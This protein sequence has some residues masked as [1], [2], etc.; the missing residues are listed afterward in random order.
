MKNL[1]SFLKIINRIITGFILSFLMIL[2]NNGVAQVQGY[3][4]PNLDQ[5]PP[6]LRNANP[7]MTDNPL[8]TVITIGNWDNF[9]LGVDFAENNMAA[10]MS[11]PAW[12]FT[13]YNINAGHHTEN[14]TDWANVTPNFGTSLAGDPVVTYDSIGNLYYINMFGSVSGIKVIKSTDNG[15]TWGTPVTGCLGEDKCWIAC[16]QT[17]GPYAN[18]VYVCMTNNVSNGVGAFAR[19]IDHGSTFTTTFSPNTQ[20]LPGMMVCV[21]PNGNIQGGSVYAVTNSGSATASTYTFY[22]STNGGQSFTLMSSQQFSGYVGTYVN[23][24]NSVEG[25]RTRPYP[26]I[27]ADNSYGPHRGRFYNIYA[28]NDP[29]GNGNKPDIWVRYSD[30]AGST[31]SA[32]IRV[33]DDP[34]PQSHNQW[35]PAPWCDKETGRLYVQWMDTRDCPTND[36]ALIYASYSDD[37]G[38]TWAANQAISNK[39]MKI[40][41]P[42]CGGG[43]TP[44]YQGDYNGIV[45]NKKV[46]MAGWTDFRD[47]TFMS[48]TAYFPDFA[49]A[50]DH[51]SDT[52]F[53]PIDST[54]FQVMIPAIKLYSD[55]V[56]V[57]GT[58]TPTPSTGTLDFVYPN[59]NIITT[60]P[61]SLAVRVVL[62]GNVPNGIY[63]ATF[64]G[65]GPNGT[66]VHLRTATI[67]VLQGNGFYVQATA[68]PGN[69]CQ[70]QTSQLNVNIIGGTP[71][72]TFLWTPSTWLNNPNIQ[73]PVATPMVSTMYHVQVTDAASK[74]ETDSVNIV[75]SSGPVQ[76]GPISGPQVVCAGT[77][78]NYSI[79]SV[80][81]AT[82]Y[83]WTVPLNATITSG[84]NTTGITVLWD[85]T[86][87]NISVIAGN[88]CGNSTPSV[89]A[90]TV[91]QAP[92][93]LGTINGPDP[94]CNNE[95]AKYYVT[96][97]GNT[98][99]YV[100]TV[101]S[102]VTIISGQGTDTIMVQWGV[103][104]D[105][106]SVFARNQCGSTPVLSKKV[107]NQALPDPAGTISGKDTICKDHTGYVFTVG[108]ITGAT[109]YNWTLPAGFTVTGGIGTN[110]ITINSGQDTLSGKISVQGSNIC[111]NGISF[112]KPLVVE[113]CS[114]ISRNDLSS[115]VTIYPNPARNE[116]F[117]KIMGQEKN[118]DLV[119]TDL[120]GKAVYKESLADLATEFS[121]KID[122]S[123]FPAGFYFIKLSSG[124]RYFAGKVVIRQE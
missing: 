55:T 102:D 89:L 62:T 71:P 106:I 59:G 95:N 33:N 64:K 76:P 72:F 17:S 13:A 63:T 10:N 52:L 16:D 35:Q 2:T 88:N 122:V 22:R 113:D 7:G 74:V 115:S 73:N 80:P 85:T 20:N 93:P 110:S 26:F 60:F 98:L 114:G 119:I 87:G 90:V 12:Y 78:T 23:S 75:V 49:M 41:C 28:S 116:L 31:W 111:G 118:L 58:I 5:V 46:S 104:A 92:A 48:T 8:S 50:L 82:S 15:A 34:N 107:N 105:T 30:N 42:S 101:P 19:S 53:S 21:G 66:P 4:D 1:N 18:Y 37:G 25:M 54:T 3:E 83:S 36:S 108:N 32:A 70:G 43:G 86:Q 96:Q 121:K 123:G 120:G 65:A 117:I 81:T 57:S 61:S 112:S 100:W 84:Q 44:E 56:V 47:G 14:G 9:D 124:T 29:P 45:S 91:D 11:N 94:V 79:S 77:S 39:K 99:D 38:V 67:R 27:A 103:K 40:F 6:Y 68:A 97:G 69:I 51:S 24:R 109:S